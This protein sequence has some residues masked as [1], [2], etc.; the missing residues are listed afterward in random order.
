MPR[1]LGSLAQL[2]IARDRYPSPKKIALH[3]LGLSAFPELKQYEDQECYF[4]S[5][6]LNSRDETIAVQMKSL[7]RKIVRL[8]IDRLRLVHPSNKGL[9][10][11]AFEGEHEGETF[12]VISMENDVASLSPSWMKKALPPAKRISVKK[13]SLVVRW[14]SGSCHGCS[15]P[16]ASTL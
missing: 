12:K 2:W 15:K 13:L 4:E 3:V 8:P 5:G 16:V 10:V 7:D 6:H 14:K 1:W 9:Y 11:L